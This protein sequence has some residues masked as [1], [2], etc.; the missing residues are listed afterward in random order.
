MAKK[1]QKAWVIQWSAAGDH[2]WAALKVS[3]YERQDEKVVMVLPSR[4]SVRQVS[5][6]VEILY[7]KA[8]YTPGEQW[9]HLIGAPD[10]VSLRHVPYPVR[11]DHDMISCGHNPHLIARKMIVEFDPED[12]VKLLER[13]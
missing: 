8:A 13:A 4:W 12:K 6:I 10:H 7:A 11:V 9:S 5:L 2:G 3:E 1:G